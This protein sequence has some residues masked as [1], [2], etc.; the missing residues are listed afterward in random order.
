M[1][2]LSR[3]LLPQSLLVILIAT[4]ANLMAANADS[5]ASTAK[6]ELLSSPA[7]INSSR[8]RI[9]ADAKGQVWLSWVTQKDTLATLSYAKLGGGVD[10]SAPNTIS[11]GHDWFNNWADFPSLVVNEN[12]MAAHWLRMS[13]DGPYDYDI[14]AA[15]LNT[16]KSTWTKGVTIHNDGVSAEHGFV[17]MRPMNNGLTFISWLDGRETRG[18][19]SHG[20]AAEGAHNNMGAMTLRAGIFG[21][22]GET[23]SEWELDR[24]VC[25]CCQTSAAM[26]SNGPVVVYRDRS[27][28]EIR[29][30]YITRYKGGAWTKPVAVHNDGWKIAGCP[31]NGPAVAASD[32]QVAVSWFTAKDDKPKVQLAVSGN[33]GETFAAPVLVASGNTNGRVGTT[34][35]DSGNIA[36]SWMDKDGSDA[37]IMLSLYS[38]DGRLLET[39]QVATSKASR[40]SGFPIIDSVGN[41][42]YVTWTNIDDVP[43]VKVARVSYFNNPG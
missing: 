28:G 26:S 23:V 30:I 42:V 36:V 25:D 35:L 40:R 11:Q 33:G 12:S 4:S 5:Q 34:I 13:A 38:H 17:S 37:K 7:P 8:S 2:F 16:G 9:I 32:N 24:R 1:K 19:E 22:N 31:V 20:V 6:L 41:E 29:D 21:A 10:W 18:D 43:R 14:Q 3:S 39:T 27:E 15:F